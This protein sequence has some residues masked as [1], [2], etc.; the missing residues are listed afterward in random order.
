M[1]ARD[2]W[3]D[4]QK[5]FP[6]RTLKRAKAR[7]PERGVY[8]ASSFEHSKAFFCYP[9]I[10]FGNQYSHRSGDVEKLVDTCIPSINLSA[11]VDIN[12]LIA[13]GRGTGP[14]KPRQPAG[15]RSSCDRC[16]FQLGA[17]ASGKR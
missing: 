8:A 1:A 13:S 17:R 6:H 2:A 14:V 4:C 15:A 10:A 7:A 11:F 12:E 5:T 9:E 3:S 16:Q